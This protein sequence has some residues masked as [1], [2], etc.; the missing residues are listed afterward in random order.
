MHLLTELIFQARVSCVICCQ[1]YE[2][3]WVPDVDQVLPQHL[4][5]PTA[6]WVK[7]QLRTVEYIVISPSAKLV[8]LSSCYPAELVTL[9]RRAVEWVPPCRFILS[10]GKYANIITSTGARI[11]FRLSWISSFHPLVTDSSVVYIFVLVVT[12][13]AFHQ[14]TY[15][16]LILSVIV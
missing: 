5:Q 15:L 14:T 10:N 12:T 13:S 2:M 4:D 7:S 8:T 3:T 11:L 9:R 6:V 1:N 16:W